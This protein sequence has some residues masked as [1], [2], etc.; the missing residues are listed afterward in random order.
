MLIL[1]FK[2]IGCSM[3]CLF[4]FGFVQFCFVVV[5]YV[6]SFVAVL[7]CFCTKSNNKTSFV[8]LLVLFWLFLC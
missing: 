7:F 3:L 8:L 6:F 4:C 5:V 1:L 2:K